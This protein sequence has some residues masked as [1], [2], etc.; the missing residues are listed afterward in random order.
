MGL[1]TFLNGREPDQLRGIQMLALS[2][3]GVTLLLTITGD[4]GG[5]GTSSWAASGTMPCRLDPASTN[6]RITGGRI[7]ERST[8]V[9]TVP[10]GAIVPENARFLVF[11]RGTFEVTATRQRTT[12]RTRTFEVMEI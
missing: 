4:S 9:V 10:A 11:G 12:E 6:S 2:D 5:G 7:D 1:S 8:H 3:V